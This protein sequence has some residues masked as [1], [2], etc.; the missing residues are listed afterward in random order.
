MAAV[1]AGTFGGIKVQLHSFTESLQK[2]HEQADAPW[3]LEVYREAFP[4]LMSSVCVRDDGWAQRGGIDRVL[5]LKCGRTVTVDEKVRYTDYPDILLEVWSDEARKVRGWV[6]KDLACDFIA[7][8]F[9]PSQT[10][11]LIPFLNLRAAWRK[12]RLAWMKAHRHVRA[13]NAGYVTLSVAVPID[14]LMTALSDAMR[15]SWGDPEQRNA[16]REVA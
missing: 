15:V 5:T 2:S 13:Q 11:Y 9:V 7:Y 10:C 14:E 16:H 8:A 1:K 4:S 12:N 6:A 3:W